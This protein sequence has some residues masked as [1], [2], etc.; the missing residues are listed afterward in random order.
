MIRAFWSRLYVLIVE[1]CASERTTEVQIFILVAEQL[2]TFIFL[3]VSQTSKM[4]IDD[5]T[6]LFEI[7]QVRHNLL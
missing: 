4:K 7:E 2:K 1:K 6:C 3:G 5:T